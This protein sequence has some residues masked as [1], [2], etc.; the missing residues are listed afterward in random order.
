MEICLE[1]VKQ[2][3]FALLYVREQTI[4]I[5]LEAVKQKEVVK[6]SRDAFIHVNHILYDCVKNAYDLL[7]N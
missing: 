4:E 2:N 1:A 6:N 7:N 3:G 5:C